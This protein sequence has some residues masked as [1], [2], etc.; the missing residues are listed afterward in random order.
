MDHPTQ[1]SWALAGEPLWPYRGPMSTS[2]IESTRAGQWR[3]ERPSFRTQV[4][5]NGWNWPM[6]TPGHTARTLIDR[7]L[8]GRELDQA[9]AD[10]SAREIALASMVEQLPSPSNRV[11]PDFAQRDAIGL[12]RPRITFRIDD[13]VRR[14]LAE[15]RRLHAEIFG[16][17][18]STEAHYSDEIM[19]SGH[20]IGTCRM[21]ADPK[22]SV[23]DAQ[24]RSHDHPNLFVLG[25][26]VFPTSAASNPTLTIAALALR[27]VGSIQAALGDSR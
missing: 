3:A 11:V 9:I 19:P 13:Y 12:P 2:G 20:V 17:L 24:L 16:A 22:Q 4:D 8:R 10:H 23:V 21:G 7:G 1:L 25:S 27:A 5:N 26:S 6:G 18:R 14:G 15:A